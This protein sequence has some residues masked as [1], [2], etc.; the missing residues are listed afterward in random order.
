MNAE[1]SRAGRGPAT[2]HPADWVTQ[3]GAVDDVLRALDADLATRRR[4]R[5][6][7]AITGVAMVALVAGLFVGV[8]YVQDTSVR[9]TQVARR[10]SVELADG[11]RAELNAR[12]IARTDFRYG[13]RVVRLEQGEAFFSVVKDSAHPFIVGTPHGEVRVTGT[14]FNVRL[15]AEQGVEV[16]LFEGAVTFAAKASETSGPVSTALQ[17]GQQVAIEGGRVIVRTLPDDRL[18]STQAWR[19]GRAVF[20]GET[21]KQAAQRFA[22]Y[23]GVVIEVSSEVAALRLGGSYPLDEL[24]GFLDAI[25]RTQPVRLF[26]QAENAYRFGPR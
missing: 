10:E 7:I 6:S 2:V 15:T 3:S 4:R 13:R 12:T 17:P 16:T 5:K 9:T 8:P 19:N 20:N 21:L 26:K 22:E 23:H 25:T 24:S 18:D 1:S 11:S 14:Q